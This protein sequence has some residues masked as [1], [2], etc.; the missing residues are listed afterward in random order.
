MPKPNFSEFLDLVVKRGTYRNIDLYANDCG[1]MVDAVLK[2]EELP[3]CLAVI[4]E[5]TG[6]EII[7][8]LPITKHRYRKNRTPA[9]D[10][11]TPNQKDFIRNHCNEEFKLLGYS[12]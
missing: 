1:L 8:K 10:I 12:A 2:F 7:S 6:I 5:H 3:N 9:V 4:E 11:L